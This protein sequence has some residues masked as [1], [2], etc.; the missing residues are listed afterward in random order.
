[1]LSSLG[2]VDEMRRDFLVTT[3]LILFLIGSTI[4]INSA[5]AVTASDS[6]V[7]A[8]ITCTFDTGAHLTVRA[9]MIVNRIN[10]FDTIY[11]RQSIEE[12]SA[13]NPYVMGAI[14]LRLHDS[15]KTLVE[16][17]FSNAEIDTLTTMPSY[18]K[19]YFIDDFRV[20]LTPAFFQHSGSL[21]LT[22]FIMGFLDMGAT[23]TYHFNLQ[24]Q[25]GWNATFVYKLPTTMRIAYANTADTNP[26]TNAITWVVRNWLGNDAGKDAT[27]SI[28]SKNPTTIA[29]DTED[30]TLEYIIDTRSVNNISFI[31]SILVKKVNIRRYSVL[32]GFITGIEIIPADGV[33]LCIDNGLF[34]WV[35]L[36]EKTIQPIEQQTTPLIENSSFKQS[37]SLSFSWD[38]D[39]TINCSTPYNIS[40]M[41]DRPALRANFSD[42]SVQLMLCQMPARAF[43]GLI[44]AGGT[45][46]ISS[47]DLNFGLGLEGIP[48]PYDII[49]HLPSNITL[50]GQKAYIWNRTTPL[51]GTFRSDLQPS[52]PYSAEHIETRIDIELVKMDLNILSIFTGKTELTASLKMKEHNHLYVIRRSD[53]LSFSPKINIT[54]LNADALRLSI[55]ENVFSNAEIDGFLTEKTERFQQR[56]SEVFQGLQVKGVIDRAVFSN[57]LVWDGDISAMDAVVPVVVSNSATE[58]HTVVF[59]LSLWPVDL[60]L[61]P[62]RFA[63]Q[64]LENQSTTYRLIFPR[65]VTV[66]ATESSG[67]PLLKGI[68]NDGR[69]YIE[70]SFEAGSTM[71]ST[72]LTCVLNVSP[73]YVLGLFLPCILVFFLLIVLVVIMYLIRKKK[74]GLRRGRG[75]IFA[76]EDNEPSEYGEQEY[77]VP[78]P[79]PSTKRRK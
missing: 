15:I 29:S 23:V 6:S 40:H 73:V 52:P 31:D 77:Y 63:L 48:Y 44:H 30:I 19:P 32:P 27:L 61:A 18:Q 16:T 1:V 38:P 35:D 42:S 33:R 54:F 25:Q 79:P 41:D 14:M 57:S 71:V 34:S 36:F 47:T 53:T 13:T 8:T 50:E 59:N 65:G 4:Y 10:V 74:G 56:L 7:E 28:Q 39:S 60:T 72:D 26:E 70:L 11:D 5:P 37:L 58:V 12:M 64:S 3:M 24:A 68:T 2:R 46:S 49:L 51:K 67:K 21:N 45:A 76:P 22:D 66:N 78:P 9:H 20:N 62:Q 75:K 43:F 55:Q 69:E 17:A